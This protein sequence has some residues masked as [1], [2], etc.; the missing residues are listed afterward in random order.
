MLP[1]MASKE[2]GKT[3]CQVKESEI[4]TSVGSVDDPVEEIE[5]W[6]AGWG[7]DLPV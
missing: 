3:D 6:K 2:S 5:R 1:V 7:A 4:Q